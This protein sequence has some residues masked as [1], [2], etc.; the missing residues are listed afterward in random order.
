MAL[1][2]RTPREAFQTL[3]DHLNRTL[4]KVLTRTRLRF[5]VRHATQDKTSLAFFDRQLRAGAVQ[6]HPS[7]PWYLSLRQD[8]QAIP[9]GRGYTLRTLQY[10][11]RIQ[12]TPSVRD[13]AEIR[14]EYVS[15]EI[16][17]NFPY[18]CHH[19]QFHRNSRSASS[20]FSLSKFHIPTGGVTIEQ[21]IRS[22]IADLGVPP[23]T[24]RWQEELQESEKQLREWFSDMC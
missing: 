1:N 3:Q 17:P 6:L 2:A 21:V 16:D 8:I 5:S 9:D 11:Y 22:L 4:N 23:L 20:A 7:L 19:V 14:F 13:E 18:S 24:E 15:P 10:A 12:R